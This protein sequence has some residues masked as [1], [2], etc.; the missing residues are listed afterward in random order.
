MEKWLS[1]LKHWFAKSTYEF[2]AV[3]SNPIIS[4]NPLFLLGRIK[5]ERRKIFLMIQTQTMLN[6]TDNSGVKKVKCIKIL[7]GY[8]KRYGLF[9]ALLRGSIQELRYKINKKTS[10]KK[11][12]IIFAVV[13]QARSR[14][15]RKDG[16]TVKFFKNSVVIVDRQE[17]PLATRALTPFFS[18]LRK[19]KGI[20][21]LSLAQSVF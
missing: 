21:L 7:G 6:V 2:R 20:R 9:S 14:L 11:G 13:V 18:E 19:K 12:D 4:N 17:K 16:Q 10:L 3:G 1:G 5:D 8:K 15:K